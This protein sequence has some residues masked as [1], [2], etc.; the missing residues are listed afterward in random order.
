MLRRGVGLLLCLVVLAGCTANRSRRM[1]S[2][3]RGA[4][5]SGGDVGVASWYGKDFHGRKTSSGEVYNMYGLSAAHRTLPFGTVLRITECQRGKS[6]H[7]TVND[8]G[9]FIAD[10]EIDLSFGAAKAIGMVADGI[11]EVGIQ[12]V[13]SPSRG[14]GAV[15]RSKRPT[16][17]ERD[18]SADFPAQPSRDG[19]ASSY[20][21][22]QV[23]GSGRF[24]VQIGAYQIK[25]N[26]LRMRERVAHHHTAVY[27][28]THDTNIGPFHRV[29]IGPYPSEAEAETIANQI[30]L[31]IVETEPIRPVVLRED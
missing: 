5:C 4:Y 11:A 27:V 29:R 26:A 7:V 13:E 2:D 25:D 12:M 20:A 10:R 28:E 24:L 18:R 23:N 1:T 16:M 31:Q 8:R 30:S 14:T 3:A 6:I 22:P 15:A 21:S 19:G 17:T 9:P